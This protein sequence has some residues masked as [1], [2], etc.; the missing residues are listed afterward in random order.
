[1]YCSEHGRNHLFAIHR[2]YYYA[3]SFPDDEGYFYMTSPSFGWHRFESYLYSGNYL[4]IES[5]ELKCGIPSGGSSEVFEVIPI[6]GQKISYRRS[7][8]CYI[9]FDSEGK[10]HGPCIADLDSGST[11]THITIAFN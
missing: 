5:G 4:M 1:M 10:V 6:V 9:A 3:F 7:K 2:H 8:D 11:K